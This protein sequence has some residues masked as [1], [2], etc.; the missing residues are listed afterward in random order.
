MLESAVL[1][2][3]G[4][5]KL[6]KRCSRY[7]YCQGGSIHYLPTREL[8]AAGLAFSLFTAGENK[9]EKLEEAAF[10]TISTTSLTLSPTTGEKISMT[11]GIGVGGY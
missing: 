10:G 9:S 8:I 11:M 7:Y 5:E 1:V 3:S 4:G 6:A 2:D